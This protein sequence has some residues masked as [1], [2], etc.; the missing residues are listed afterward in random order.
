MDISEARQWTG[1]RR[2]PWEMARARVVEA[3]LT[4]S[5]SWRIGPQST[6]VDVGCGDAFLINRWSSRFPSACFSGI[7]TALAEGDASRNK[8]SVKLFRSLA[9]A[10][11]IGKVSHVLLLDVLEHVPD[12]RRL[13]QEISASLSISAATVFVITVPAF[14]CLFTGHDISLGHYRRYSRKSLCRLLSMSGMVID[15]SGYFFSLLLIPRLLRGIREK[16]F[17]C[18]TARNGLIGGAGL[19]GAVGW[20]LEQFLVADYRC[21]AF[22]RCCGFQTPGLSV[23]AV[24]RKP[25]YS[26]P[27]SMKLRV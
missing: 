6:V 1:C 2:H 13:L 7:D 9:Q 16:A 22:L 23:F 5:S 17:G 10:A 8:S 20:L 11:S 26:S 21:S 4:T 18:G 12:E 27:A 14:R 24:C 19:H 3:L 25:A 15:K